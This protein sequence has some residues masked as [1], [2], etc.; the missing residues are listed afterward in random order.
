MHIFLDFR[1]GLTLEMAVHT[2]I[3][4]TGIYFMLRK[5]GISRLSAWI[6]ASHVGIGVF[7]INAICHFLP[8]I[9]TMSWTPWSTGFWVE[10]VRT[11]KSGNLIGFIILLAIEMIAGHNEVAMYHIFTIGLLYGLFALLNVDDWRNAGRLILTLPAGI[12][13]AALAAIIL[14][15][16]MELLN[17]SVRRNGITYEYFSGKATAGLG[18]L[19]DLNF[20]QTIILVV[21]LIAF[22]WYLK[23]KKILATLLLALIIITFQ[24]NI[25]GALR[26]FFRLPL[27]NS[28]AQ[29]Y[30][31]YSGLIIT[32]ALLVGFTMEKINSDKPARKQLFVIL[33]IIFSAFHSFEGIIAR[34]FIPEGTN[35]LTPELYKSLKIGASARGAFSILATII[36]SYLAFKWGK[37]RNQ[38]RPGVA[39]LILFFVA[40]LPS[41]L[42]FVPRIKKNT[43]AFNGEFAD[44][45]QK[46]YNDGRFLTVFRWGELPREIPP[47]MG[48]YWR[49]RGIDA[50][51]R[52]ISWWY[53]LYLDQIDPSVMTLKNGKLSDFKAHYLF[54]SGDF[55]SYEKLKLL[56][57]LGLRYIA[58]WKKNFHLASHYYIAFDVNKKDFPNINIYRE[59]WNKSPGESFV[60]ESKSN[61]AWKFKINVLERDELRFGLIAS[62]KSLVNTQNLKASVYAA[63]ESG[64]NEK[65][66]FSHTIPLSS[67]TGD[68]PPPLYSVPL[69]EF[70]HKTIILKFLGEGQVNNTS[71]IWVAP[72]IFH[73]DAPLKKLNLQTV[74]IYENE[75]AL[76]RLTFAGQYVVIHDE[77]QRL[78]F[79]SGPAFNPPDVAVLEENPPIGVAQYP[80]ASD[81]AHLLSWEKDEADLLKIKVALEKPGVVVI[82]DSYFPG[83][84]LFVDGKPGKIYKVNEAFRGV[85]IEAGQHS[86]EMS[87]YP[88]SL[89]IGLW[90]T[91]ASLFVITI[92]SFRKSRRL[93]FRLD[94]NQIMV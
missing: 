80:P 68:A 70:E 36:F 32:M 54:K 42:A 84:R 74:D 37:S 56:D 78:K 43:F 64:A 4:S 41:S 71:I 3:F 82:A 60:V 25:F 77:E 30:K 86:I 34:S 79:I 88:H 6:S 63:D 16:S 61:G 94:E 58:S 12:A 1:R 13:A 15:P 90:T 89:R 14:I 29:S 52:G 10:W 59:Q 50:C 67:A 57:F 19:M 5:F 18:K 69:D 66:L 72:Q 7:I 53:A 51:V 62:G 39:A 83:W 47:Q 24:W 65:I 8:E 33:L 23:D 85:P 81:E 27:T 44:F 9:Y 26:L 75:A 31:L 93:L 87:Y 91:I 48:G 49:T 28:F 2:L 76:P 35:T 46:H 22:L 92:V 45:A 11:K 38:A 21:V 73:P 55:F 40:V 17:Y 20:D